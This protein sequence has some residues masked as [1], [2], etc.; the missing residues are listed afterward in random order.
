MAPLTL[1]EL[2]NHP[3]FPK[4]TW[5]LKPTQKGK[6]SVAK[7]RGGPFNVSYEVHGTGPVHIIVCIYYHVYESHY[8]TT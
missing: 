4:T 2:V 6:V 3:E 1:D 8:Y 7:G 5:D